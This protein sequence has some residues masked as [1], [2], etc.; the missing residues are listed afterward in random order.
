M[1]AQDTVP[2]VEMDLKVVNVKPCMGE[3]RKC[4]FEMIAP[5]RRWLLQA[6]HQNGGCCVA[7]GVRD[8]A[9][10]VVCWRRAQRQ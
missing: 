8:S 10:R 4:M 3:D 7:A 9:E 5:D 2:A 1:R 6:E